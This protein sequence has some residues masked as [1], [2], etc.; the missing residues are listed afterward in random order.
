MNFLHSGSLGDIIYAL[1]TVKALTGKLRRAN[2]YLKADVPDGIPV[3]AGQ[4]QRYRMSREEAGKLLGLLAQ[5]PGIGEAALYD[6]Q[7]VDIDLDRFRE[8]GF[9]YDR[10]DITRFYAYAFK[11]LPRTWE[12]RL[13]VQPS[14][15]YADRVLVNRTTRYV[16][17]AV[18]YGFLA[19]RP[20]VYFVGYQEDYQAFVKGCPRIPHLLAP[21]ALT[22]ASWVA[23]CKALVGNQSFPFALAEALKVPR[24]LEVFPGCPNVRPNGP[25]GWEAIGQEM[26]QQIVEDLAK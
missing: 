8:T 5:Q 18:S 23:G 12:P 19:G 25:K 21:D 15:Q 22:L 6:G 14:D 2:L 13:K 17:R 16:N 7:A 4:R 1:P 24:C 26:F 11:C 10:G 3:W 9:G 20:K